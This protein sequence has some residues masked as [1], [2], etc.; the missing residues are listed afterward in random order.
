M[1]NKFSKFYFSE[2]ASDNHEISEMTKLFFE[3]GKDKVVVNEKYEGKIFCYVCHKAPLNINFG[4]ER[5]YLSVLQSNQ[6]L[7]E[8][9]CWKSVDEADKKEVDHFFSPEEIDK[10]YINKRLELFLSSISRIPKQTSKNFSEVLTGREINEINSLTIK[11]LSRKQKHLPKRK[12]TVALRDEGESDI[13]KIYYG[14][15]KLYL[16][17]FTPKGKDK[18]VKYY[19]K[20]LDNNTNDLICELA[21]SPFV[22]VY[23][24]KEIAAKIPPGYFTKKEEYLEYAT[25]YKIAFVSKM[26]IETNGNFKNVKGILADSRMLFID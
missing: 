16:Y 7:H 26:N 12:L 23:I 25:S 20:V 22:Y 4:P 21:I 15:C 11:T 3:N 8:T 14:T 9:G 2:D 10:S 5:Q 24:S 19:L 6:Y 1:D 17:A 13:Y 18:I